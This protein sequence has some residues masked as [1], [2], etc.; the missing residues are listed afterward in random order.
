MSWASTRKT[1]YILVLLIILIGIAAFVYFQ[2]FYQKPTCTDNIQ[3]QNEQG[4]DCGG[5]CPVICNFN[6]TNPIV[7][8]SRTFK[9]DGSLHNAI[10]FIENPNFEFEAF[11]VPYSVKIYDKENILISEISGTTHIPA[12][13][14]IPVFEKAI[15]LGKRIPQR[16]FFEFTNAP[17]WTKVKEEQPLLSIQNKQISNTSDKPRLYAIIQNKS[18]VTVKDIE[19]TAI[20]FDPDGNVI[21]I[22][23][24]FVDSLKKNESE[25]IVFTWKEPFTRPTSRIEII[26]IIKTD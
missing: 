21:D 8:W 4:I 19:I 20:I 12:G 6:V 18:V 22:S 10:A 26:P 13:G 11:N 3:N 17:V 7:L 16:T 25:E 9:I 2:F 23:Q 5:V 15:D 1:T 24:T 14:F